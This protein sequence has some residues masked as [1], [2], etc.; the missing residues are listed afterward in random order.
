MKKSPSTLS[1]DVHSIDAMIKKTIHPV[2]VI[3]LILLVILIS[4]CAGQDGTG[5][6]NAGQTEEDNEDISEYLP[7]TT[8]SRTEGVLPLAVTFDAVNTTFPAWSS[9]VIQP[10]GFYD[11]PVNCTGVKI[12]KV[13][14]FTNAGEGRLFY[15][16]DSTSLRWQAPGDAGAGVS[17]DVS[18][19]GTFTIF[20][21]NDQY[22][23]DVWVDPARLP[24][25]D[26]SDTIQIVEGGENADYSTFR[27]KWCFDDPDSGNWEAGATFSDGTYPSKNIAVG[28][29]AGHLFLNTGTYTVTLEVNDDENNT[30]YYSEDI[31]VV[32]EPSGGWT[33]YYFAENGDDINGDGSIA[34]P[35]GTIEHAKTLEAN[36][37]KFLFR[38]GDT[39]DIE[40]PWRIDSATISIEAYGTG[41]KPKIVMSD[42]ENVF[43]LRNAIDAR[44]IEIIISGNLSDDERWD[45]LNP[46]LYSG[47]HGLLYKV[48]TDNTGTSSIGSSS[49][50]TLI[51]EFKGTN[52]I[53]NFWIEN[54]YPTVVLG[55]SFTD[56]K[57]DNSVQIYEAPFRTIDNK[58][59][60]SHS[61]FSRC[62]PKYMIRFMGNDGSGSD[63]RGKWC[64]ASYNRLEDS[65]F[66][67]TDENSDTK[68]VK[69][70]LI[71][72]NTISQ[73]YENRVGFRLFSGQHVT[74]R[75]N[76]FKSSA[77]NSFIYVGDGYNAYDF[78]YHGVHIF[79]NTVM[80]TGPDQ[81]LYFLSFSTGM[82]GK[83]SNFIIKNNIF[84][85]PDTTNGR[86]IRIND[87]LASDPLIESDNNIIYAPNS[88]DIIFSDNN[89]T[90]DLATWQSYGN[91][92]NS[93]TADPLLNAPDNGD[94]QLRSG[95]P[96]IDA[97]SNEV[98]P[99]APY[100]F[101]GSQR[102]IDEIDMGA[103]EY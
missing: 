6:S 90:M 11:H 101:D 97:G 55:S 7:M 8:A 2:F 92:I 61:D 67:P 95:S 25:S 48:E 88:V 72:N 20:S 91:D 64:I 76:T 65:G 28:Y 35:Y 54:D 102:F 12:N 15:L 51:Q 47:E 19:G 94:F 46:F 31:S 32:A 33:E 27:Y 103:F 57:V 80:T 29:L 77:S 53:M 68:I 79:N 43:N 13:N 85:A 1:R 75:N 50:H 86:F 81:F 37:T 93:M 42:N 41:E 73:T 45:Y 89:G 100:D 44:F 5:E 40:S 71:E 26:T 10:R 24:S 99:W 87:F 74:I 3:C 49:G 36:K 22:K 52:N 63:H 18:G 17:V 16:G 58:L 69:N 82:I 84:V 78:H 14:V 21:N 70:V 56:N 59:V 98:L 30:H 60:L 38:R 66:Q 39:F 4:G 96:C 9:N 83:T 34:N 62:G 23:L